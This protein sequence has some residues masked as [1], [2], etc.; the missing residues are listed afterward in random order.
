MTMSVVFD[1]RNGFRA[2]RLVA[3]DASSMLHGLI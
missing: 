1:P 2:L 3:G